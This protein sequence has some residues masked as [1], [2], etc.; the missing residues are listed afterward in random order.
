LRLSRWFLSLNLFSHFGFLL[1][2]VLRVVDDHAPQAVGLC[3]LLL[4][5]SNWLVSLLQLLKSIA[6]LRDL[7]VLG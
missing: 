3:W 6:E 7:G 5:D 1:S 4:G 2:L